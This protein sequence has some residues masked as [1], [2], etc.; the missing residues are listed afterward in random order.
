MTTNGIEHKH[1]VALGM[2]FTFY[3]VIIL[4]SL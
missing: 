3:M 4:I 2:Y 1:K